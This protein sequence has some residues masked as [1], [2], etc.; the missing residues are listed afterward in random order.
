MH[1]SSKYSCRTPSIGCCN[2]V[3]GP[4]DSMRI[5]TIVR[6]TKNLKVNLGANVSMNTWLLTTLA[7]ILCFRHV[8]L[9]PF[10]N[11]YLSNNEAGYLSIGQGC[12]PLG[13]CRHVLRCPSVVHLEDGQEKGCLVQSDSHQ[14]R[15]ILCRSTWHRSIV[16]E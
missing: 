11:P 12:T 15:Q 7:G 13:Y 8:S 4:V 10:W 16:Q 14:L 2:F 3:Q 6:V 1:G 9:Q 5:R